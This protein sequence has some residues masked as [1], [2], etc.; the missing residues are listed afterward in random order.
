MD[1][2]RPTP[3][4]NESFL[5]ERRTNSSL[6]KLP[7]TGGGATSKFK[8]PLS[9]NTCKL[10]QSGNELVIDDSDAGYATP[11]DSSEFVDVKNGNLWN[12][13]DIADDDDKTPTNEN[14][15]EIDFVAAAAEAAATTDAERDENSNQLLDESKMK[16]Y[17]I[18]IDSH[19]DK[20]KKDCLKKT[21]IAPPTPTTPT[22]PTTPSALL[23]LPKNSGSF[24]HSMFAKS[25]DKMSPLLMSDRRTSQFY[26]E[27]DEDV[28]NGEP[29]DASPTPDT[30]TTPTANGN[31]AKNVETAALTEGTTPTTVDLKRTK[32]RPLSSVSISSTSSSSS[33]G[34][35]EMSPNQT[36]ISY[37]AS[38]ESLADHSESESPRIANSITVLERACMEIVDSEQNYV[39]DLCQVING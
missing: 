24:L 20:Q 37:L 33:T 14:V 7:H 3:I 12:G 16:L 39:D 35:D 27:Q 8:H 19:G 38:V 36:A 6:A 28:P 4:G 9:K 15:P 11:S 13:G 17:A 30:T 34:S 10:S 32:T 29:V 22:T 5:H 1:E 25:D 26:V 21:S 23:N 2:S 31:S 18:V